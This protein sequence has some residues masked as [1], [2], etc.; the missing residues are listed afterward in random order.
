MRL[1]PRQQRL[2]LA[3]LAWEAN[4]LVPVDRLIEWVWPDEPPRRATQAIRVYVS[5]LRSALTGAGIDVNAL[6]VI[7]QGP[8]YLLRVDPDWIDVHR[9]QRLIGEARVAVTDHARVALLDQALALW[10]GPALADIATSD[11]AHRLS[12]RLAE[13]RGLAGEDRFDALLR[14]GKA[15]ELL[16]ELAIAVDEQP[17]RERLAGQWLLALYRS[18]QKD[19]ALAEFRATRALLADE[20]GIDTGP[21]L[22][23]LELAIL[24]DDPALRVRPEPSA[25]R[26]AV[27]AMLPP[28]VTDFTG[29]DDA[30]AWLD[31]LL[32]RPDR[33]MAVVISAIA[34]TA[35]S[36]R[37]RSRCGGRTRCGRSSRT[38]SCT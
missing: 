10:R 33:P 1:G 12:A 24:R 25:E 18:G 13:A 8:G 22:R 21:E 4:R 23:D 2:V 31:A 19:K 30:L 32:D 3:V 36:A 35:G 7:T 29:R 17:S 14:L 15:T 28:G 38:A 6:A 26:P 5:N 27:P 20:L 11:V 16:D 9:F 37:P 34:G